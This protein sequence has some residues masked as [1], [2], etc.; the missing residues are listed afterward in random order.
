MNKMLILLL[1]LVA[2]FSL[3]AQQISNQVINSTGG[4]RQSIGTFSVEFS[5]GEPITTTLSSASI[6]LTQGFLQ[7]EINRVIPV[8]LLFFNAALKNKQTAHLT[9]ATSSELNADYFSVEKSQNGKDFTAVG[10][11]KAVG[12]SSQ[13]NDYFYD[14]LVLNS[15]KIIYYRLKQLD[16][17]GAFKYTQVVA[18]S[19]Q[20]EHQDG[21]KIYPN[22]A[23]NTITIESINPVKSVNIYNVQGILIK[24]SKRTDIDISDCAAGVYLLEVENTEGTLSRIKFIKL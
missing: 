15:D 21:V 12:N 10:K 11:V 22:P 5:L 16:L 4:F 3:K 17:N 23:K 19:L 6:K 18:I 13:K 2:S 20:N 7:P 1:F 24:Q 8:E 9:W 14:D